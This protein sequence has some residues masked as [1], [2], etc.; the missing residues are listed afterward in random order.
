MLQ[1][2]ANI[3]GNAVKL[4]IFDTFQEVER[5]WRDFQG[6]GVATPYQQYGWLEPWFRHVGRE[7]GI[8]PVIVCGE[9]NGAPAFF[10]PFGIQRIGGLKV[11]RWLGGKQ[12]NYNFGLY[13]PEILPRL[14]AATVK[15]FLHTISERS[16]GI[17]VFEFFNQPQAWNG[18]VNP[19][20]AFEQQISPSPCYRLDLQKDFESLEKARRNPRSIQTLRRKARKL[21]GEHGE[22]KIASPAD[23]EEF[24]KVFDGFMEQRAI[25]FDAMGVQN[26]FAGT[27][28]R[29]FLEE[30]SRP[31]ESGEAPVMPF[32]ALSAGGEVCATYAGLTLN[33][34]YSCFINSIDGDR[35]GKFSPGD[36]LLRGVIEECCDAGFVGF[37]LGMGNE[38][39]KTS[40]CDEDPLFDCFVPITAL[41]L[42][43][44]V[45]I[46]TMLSL[47]R[48]IRS[49]PKL[50]SFAKSIRKQL[51]AKAAPD[52]E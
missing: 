2:S 27:G 1:M 45:R 43:H 40:W 18:V 11:C 14:D 42:L 4:R 3:A 31:S 24:A 23:P 32:H 20:A 7:Q 5:E 52:A 35:F 36:I 38:R 28:L 37:D 41:G 49:N 8:R 33:G 44:T 16:G 34:H 13:D 10:W 15:A 50:W 46:R 39:Y 19:F 9:A 6:R 48:T 17:D 51:H 29:A 12:S 21:A 22:T 26:V 47:K 25:R 30:V